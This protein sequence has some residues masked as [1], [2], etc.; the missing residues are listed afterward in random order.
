M[1]N[2]VLRT[3]FIICLGVNYVQLREIKTNVPQW[4]L[5]IFTQSWP[6][7]VCI[8]WKEH[9]HSH[10][11][12]LPTNKDSWTIHGIWPTKLGTIGP[13]FC[14]RTWHFDPEQ[15]RPI[16]KNLEQLWTNVESGTSTYALWAHEWN[17]HGTCAAVL[18]PLNSELKY[19]N[20]GLAWSQKF[21]VHD[22][23][24]AS[25]IVPSN[26][27]E[28]SV[29]DMY[30]SIK[31]KLGVNPVIE[32]RKEKGKSY[33]GEIRICFTKTLDLHDCDGV[34]NLKAKMYEGK[35]ILTN[36]D[37]SQGVLY[38]HYPSN[39]YVNLYKLAMWLQWLTL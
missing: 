26:T 19:F 25:G 4:D 8:E 16:E 6:A 5:L 7:T 20:M 15:V 2:A 34:L 14:N 23:L 28:Y 31:N 12:N 36:C 33:L 22:I 21:M 10:T 17:K 35:S 27:N 39:T 32:C 24:Q 18:E 37:T 11:C 29:L 3:S 38:P 30:N 13:A 9:D 1:I